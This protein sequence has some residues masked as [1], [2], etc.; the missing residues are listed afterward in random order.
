MA[1]KKKKA[2]KPAKRPAKRPA[3]K[4]AKNAATKAP[5]KVVAKVTPLL[6]V[7]EIEPCIPFWTRIGFEKTVEVPEGDR[8][9]FVILV[10]DGYEIMYQS[11]ASIAAD[12]P[13]AATAPMG[14]SFLFI[15]VQDLDAV[16]QKV[17]GAPVVFPRR[18]TFYG[19]EEIGVREPGGNAIT[20]AMPV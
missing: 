16:A 8:I 14:G 17:S 5:R 6:M 1:A 3:K 2:K 13:A 10:K 7:R 9:G 11:V 20:F 15:E 18:K 4:A 12:V 19:M